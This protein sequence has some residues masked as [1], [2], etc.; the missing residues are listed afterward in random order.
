MSALWA[1]AKRIVSVGITH[2]WRVNSARETFFTSVSVRQLPSS[3]HRLIS[4]VLER[5]SN[6][7]VALV[8]VH[9]TQLTSPLDC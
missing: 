1:R 7:F 3:A 5:I 2:D 9:V 6:A 8:S 4:S